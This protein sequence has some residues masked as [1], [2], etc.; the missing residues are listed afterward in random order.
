MEIIVVNQ[1]TA[2]AYYIAKSLDNVKPIQEIHKNASSN[3][4]SASNNKETG[5]DKINITA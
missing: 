4:Q 3:A 1:Q 5:Q 2:A